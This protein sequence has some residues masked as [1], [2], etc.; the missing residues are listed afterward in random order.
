[1]GHNGGPGVDVL[2]DTPLPGY[3]LPVRLTD[4]TVFYAASGGSGGA[5]LTDAQLRALPVPVFGIPNLPT[6]PRL[7]SA[8]IS[9]SAGGNNVLVPGIAGQTIRVFKLFLVFGS[10]TAA[11][12]RSG[13]NPTSGSLPISAGG[14]VVLDLDTEPWFFTDPGVDLVLN[15][16]ST[17]IVG[18]AVYYTQS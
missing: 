3:Y 14:S 8:P 4:G 2:P 12:F 9:I 10:A 15:T 17:S 6:A 18:G 5:G 7:S 1:M 16:T 11:T 13:T